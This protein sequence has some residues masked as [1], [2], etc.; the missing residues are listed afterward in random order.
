VRIVLVHGVL[1]FGRLPS[2]VGIPVVRYFN[3]VAAHLGARHR[4]VEPS[5]NPIGSVAE[6]GDQ[7]AREIER[8]P[9]APE[10]KVHIIAHS[11]GGLDA[12]HAIGKVGDRVAGL[13]TIG[14]PYLGSP[15]ADAIAHRRGPLAGRLPTWLEDAFSRTALIDLT[16]EVATAAMAATADA[17]GIRY[18]DVAGDASRG[19]TTLAL[20]H[21]AAAIGGITG[22]INDGV[23]TRRSALVPG[24]RHLP[25]W[26]VDHAGEIGWGY[27]FPLPASWPL[28][29]LWPPAR[30]HFARYDAIVQSFAGA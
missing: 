7:L 25:D 24:H 22:E 30:A 28:A 11:M 8:L 1:G 29:G 17:P 6:R 27:E 15:V 3:G 10:E 4:V 13:A 21:V 2:L 16:T 23:V 12:R 5:L 18:V 26:P 9:L 20:F 14:T 19:S